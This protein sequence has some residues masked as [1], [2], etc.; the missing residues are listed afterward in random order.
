MLNSPS[1]KITVPYFIY[2]MGPGLLRHTFL[3]TCY[4][5]PRRE[6]IV[7]VL[8][9]LKMIYTPNLVPVKTASRISL[10]RPKICALLGFVPI[11]GFQTGF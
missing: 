5:L 7:R 10:N 8:D 9:R 2:T 4:A 3:N 11:S 6:N 1:F